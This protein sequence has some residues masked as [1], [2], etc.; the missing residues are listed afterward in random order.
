MCKA[1]MEMRQEAVSEGRLEGKIEGKVF[2]YIELGKSREWIMEH[3]GIDSDEYNK[4]YE[5]L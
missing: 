3:L 2:A 5:N 1:I 4:I